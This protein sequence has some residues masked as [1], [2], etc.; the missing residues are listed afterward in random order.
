MKE[1]SPKEKL[2]EQIGIKDIDQKKP[3]LLQVLEKYLSGGMA[4]YS[5]MKS[6][7]PGGI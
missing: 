2:I 4:Q 7:P 1:E 6:S 3:L 5:G